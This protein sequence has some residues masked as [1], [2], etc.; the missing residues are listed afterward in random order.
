MPPQKSYDRLYTTTTTTTTKDY[1]LANNITSNVCDDDIGGPNCPHFTGPIAVYRF[2][3]AMVLF[4]GIFSLLTLGVSTSRSIRAHIHNGF[5]L[6]KIIFA[7]FLTSISF[8]L[9]FFGLI[10]TSNFWNLNPNLK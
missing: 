4:F 8:K 7:L 6:W 3:F 10:K 9:P 1:Y 2:S 5:W